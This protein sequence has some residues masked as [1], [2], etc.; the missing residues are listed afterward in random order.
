MFLPSLT[1]AIP[2]RGA[3]RTP[4]VS[5]ARPVRTAWSIASSV[6]LNLYF[7]SFTISFAISNETSSLLPIFFVAA[8]IFGAIPLG[9]TS[10][11]TRAAISK[12]CGIST[13]NSGSNPFFL[14]SVAIE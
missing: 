3:T 1:S 7:F 13:L 14:A 8:R 11:S 4:S 2:S 5:I 9:P 10:C 12:A 6:L